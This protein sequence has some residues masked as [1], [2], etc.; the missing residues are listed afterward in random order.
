MSLSFEDYSATK[1][2][3]DKSNKILNQIEFDVLGKENF[4][5]YEVLISI[6]EALG[7]ISK[8][9]VNGISNAFSSSLLE[10]LGKYAL[11]NYQLSNT[12][13]EPL[14]LDDPTDTT[15]THEEETKNGQTE[16]ALGE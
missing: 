2:H 3:L 15:D 16:D 10:V 11:E 13:E 12:T 5:S 7:A 9:V 6:A 1:N 4:S 8:A 14:L